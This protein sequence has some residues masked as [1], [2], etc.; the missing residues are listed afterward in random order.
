[1]APEAV[2]RLE[3][4][5]AVARLLPAGDRR[6]EVVRMDHGARLQR[7]RAGET[8]VLVPALVE[9]RRPALGIRR[10]D[11]LRQR[12]G[13]RAVALLALAPLRSELLDAQQLL[14]PAHLLACQPQVDEDGHLRPQDV[15][16]ERLHQV[17]DG[18]GLVAAEDVLR[19]LR[20]GG[21]EDD[22]HVARSLALLDQRGRLEAVEVGHLDVEQDER[23][24]VV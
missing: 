13:E 18:A 23:E 4:A 11:D 19:L 24:V 14:R 1:M 15:R 3:D 20:D 2:L 21:Q 6:A 22:R 5:V 12:L 7:S 17:V 9:V 8:G 16:V 10:P